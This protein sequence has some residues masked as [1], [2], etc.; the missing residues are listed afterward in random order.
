MSTTF[1]ISFSGTQAAQHGIP[2]GGY[3]EIY[4]NNE[5]EAREI[6]A[7]WFPAT[8][9]LPFGAWGEMYTEDQIIEKA[10]YFPAGLIG[11]ANETHRTWCIGGEAA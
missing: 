6:A 3:V 5:E 7:K 9:S 8:P 10:Q 4:A 11:V 2:R 1:Y